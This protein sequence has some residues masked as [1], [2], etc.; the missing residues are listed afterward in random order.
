MIF[1]ISPLF[2]VVCYWFPM[3]FVSNYIQADKEK[4]RIKNKGL[5]TNL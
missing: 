3:L 2:F 4:R 5:M 1:V